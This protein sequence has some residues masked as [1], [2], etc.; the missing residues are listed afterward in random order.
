[1]ADKLFIVAM[2]VDEDELKDAKNLSDN[3]AEDFHRGNRTTD[4]S[5][6]AYLIQRHAYD[7]GRMVGRF[8]VLN[9]VTSY[10]AAMARLADFLHA[11]GH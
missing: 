3:D 11:E 8:L 9:C 10:V 6:M 5:L 1:M 7:G 4:I 2:W